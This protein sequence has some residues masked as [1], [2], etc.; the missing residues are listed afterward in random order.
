MPRNAEVQ[1]ELDAMY[2]T[3]RIT[4]DPSALR[5]VGLETIDGQGLHHLTALPGRVPYTSGTFDALDLY[6]LADGTPVL[7]QGV[8]TN[9]AP[10]VTVVGKTAVKYSDLGVPSRSRPQAPRRD[11]RAGRR[12]DGR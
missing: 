12:P 6:V 11:S 5:Y 10:G 7:M 2:R 1:Q 8:F 3:V 4:D 9:K